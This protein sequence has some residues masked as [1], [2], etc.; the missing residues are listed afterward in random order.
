MKII[1]SKVRKSTDVLIIPFWEKSKRAEPGV[2]ISSIRKWIDAPLRQKDFS[3]KKNETC[4]IYP[5]KQKEKR[6]LLLGL[7]KKEDAS[8]DDIRISY[9]EAIKLCIAKKLHNV[10]T[11]FPEKTQGEKNRIIK[12]AV[13]GVCL[14]NYVFD[15]YQK[16]KASLIKLFYLIGCNDKEYDNV[17]KIPQIVEGVFLARDLVCENADV[18]TP[19]KLAEKALDLQK[20]STKIKV[21][22]FKK[23]DIEK[24]NMNLLLA[25]NKGSRSDPVFIEI[26]YSNNLHEKDRTVIVGKGV[27]YDSG[28]LCLKPADSMLTMKDD[29]SGAAAIL[30]TMHALIKLKT[31]INVTALIPA[32]ENS[33]GPD[34]YKPGDVFSSMSKK[35]VEI[36]NT[37][38]EGRLI[39]A[40]ALFY[41]VDKIKPDRIVNLATLTGAIVI[42]LGEEIS[43]LFSDDDKLAKSLKEA[44]DRTGESL[45]RLPL[46]ASY[47]ELLKSEIAEIKNCGSRAAGSITAALFL[48]QF[49]KNIPWAHIDIAGTSWQKKAKGYYSSQ[50]TGVGVRLLV[51]WLEELSRKK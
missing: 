28:G 17:K 24:L 6:F 10:S 21:R 11:F 5:Q 18:V 38:A 15:K 44:G 30:G 39:L 48:K 25:V 41:G 34:S 20:L 33:I 29:M 43:G 16:E 22:I 47:M 32:T 23:K 40:D 35:T 49:V 51:E 9:G 42:A 46:P 13:E 4:L 36:I 14:S 2:S 26:N 50:G 37:D 7:G 45:W 27:T 19:Q 8:L 3:G 31:K 1:Y 12:A